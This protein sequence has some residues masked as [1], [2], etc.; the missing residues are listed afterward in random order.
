MGVVWVVW[1]C[2]F[3]GEEARTVHPPILPSTHPPTGSYPAV[4]FFLLVLLGR[5]ILG[6]LVQEGIF[7]RR[8]A[9]SQGCTIAGATHLQLCAMIRPTPSRG[10]ETHSDLHRRRDSLAAYR[11]TPRILKRNFTRSKQH[12][13]ICNKGE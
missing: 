9:G 11:T 7:L 3:H 1:L 13:H 5:K 10:F 4:S 6:Y 12:T 2:G 8:L